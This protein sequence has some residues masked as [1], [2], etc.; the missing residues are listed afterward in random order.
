MNYSFL[1]IQLLVWGLSCFFLPACKDMEVPAAPIV[2]GTFYNLSGSQSGLDLPAYRGAM[3]AADQL[4]QDGGVLG[5]PL[6]LMLRDGLSEPA[7][8]QQQALQQFRT[9]PET[10][11]CIGLSD[12]DMLL[13][14]AEVTADS[15]RVFLTSGAT[16]PK[17]PAQVP[18]YLFLACFGDNVQAAAAAEFAYQYK[19]ARKVAVVYD[20]VETY[21]SLLQGYFI[22]RFKQLGGQ[23]LSLQGYNQSD[24]SPVTAQLQGA[25]LIFLAAMPD[26]A[27]PAV[28]LIRNAGFDLPIIGGDGFDSE[29]TWTGQAAISD[30]FYTTHA[31]LKADNPDPRVQA[32]RTA[33]ESAY[34]YEPD[35]FAALGYD[36]VNLLA[37]AISNA[38]SVEPADI[39]NALAAVQD[40]EGVTGKISYSD[41]S[42]IPRKSVTIMEIQAG[43]LGLVMQLL[44][45]QVPPP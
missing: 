31:Y 40:F 24:L 4:N 11:A 20:S 15:G 38:Q 5:N 45:G 1:K 33:Y 41:G 10:A 27:L 19:N 7:L 12:T 18:D 14:A 32:F 39:R 35:A 44:P 43:K 3:L 21:T 42:R 36:T 28:Q 22:T 25:D 8:L 6:F 13:A 9:N 30:V 23:I 17:L 26:E 2:I 37:E 34:G 16:S 29:S